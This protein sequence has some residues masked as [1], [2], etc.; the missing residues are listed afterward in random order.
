MNPALPAPS[1]SS[2]TPDLRLVLGLPFS[3]VSADGAVDRCLEIIEARNPRH[4]ITA[5]VDFLALAESDPAVRRLWFE[6]DEIFC[7]GMPLVW[8]SRGFDR[9]RGGL[10]ER[11]TGSDLVPRLLEQ[12]AERGH[13]V[14][15]LGS[16][17][18]TMSRLKST[19]A[20]T[21]PDLEIAGAISPPMGA[22]ED[23]DNERY[24]EEIRRTRPDVLLV[25]VGFPKQDRWIRRFR[26][27]VRVPLMVGVGAS[28]D[29]IVG[30]QVRSPRWMQRAG[31]EWAWRLATDPRR[32][33]KRYVKDALALVR[34]LVRQ[35]RF[36][37]ADRLPSLRS[38]P[39]ERQG[40]LSGARW[41]NSCRVLRWDAVEGNAVGAPAEEG[42]DVVFDLSDVETL[43]PRL[44]ESLVDAARDSRRHEGRF[45]IFG[46]S[47]RLR[48]YLQ[49]YGLGNGLWP[50]FDSP[51]A[52]TAWLG[53]GAIP[54][55]Q[56]A[57]DA[58]AH[59]FDWASEE[60]V[61]ACGI[62]PGTGQAIRVDLGGGDPL[63]RGA[64]ERLT[65]FV[66]QMRELGRWV[67]F[68]NLDE[69]GQDA[70]EIVIG[71]RVAA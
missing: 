10:P 30:K 21:L 50:V 22:I 51:V 65:R 68:T 25:A 40:C 42:T 53:I 54:G 31:L 64:A 43:D 56:L 34:A 67:V 13:S 66:S 33:A 37:I 1:L 60:L 24:L 71:D 4:V 69:R 36:S 47:H 12:C 27:Q 63:A 39:V 20:E 41:E 58:G 15:F 7:D 48:D 8:A 16:D 62:E 45:A 46:A 28:L 61:Q 9:D 35:A 17:D 18:P 6:A 38:R 59:A 29:F 44:L 57:T 3:P 26:D 49:A 14:F 23:W 32:L 55:N 2:E 19:L 5:N 52:L 11:V 70:L